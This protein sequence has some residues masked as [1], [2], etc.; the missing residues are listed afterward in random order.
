MRQ[1]DTPYSPQPPPTPAPGPIS[2][3][4]MFIASM[5]LTQFSIVNL[6]DVKAV[7]LS[8]PQ[9]STTIDPERTAL[10][11]TSDG[12]INETE[13][14]PGKSAR[15]KNMD[16]TACMS[17]TFGWV[18]EW[19][20]VFSIVVSTYGSCVAYLL[21]IR[22]NMSKFFPHAFEERDA[23]VWVSCVPLCALA[24]PDSVGFLAPF[25]LLGL[26]A[27]FAFA[28]VVVYNAVDE[29]SPDQ[30][31]HNLND[32]PAFRPATFPLALSIAAFCNEG[33]V[34]L[35]PTTHAAMKRPETYT[36]TAFWGIC[37]FIVCY[38]AVG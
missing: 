3:V 10:L 29:M 35:T 6:I 33:I 20:A 26:A 21:F 4:F 25:S 27:A 13:G 32:S 23:W 14:L 17:E 31:M 28:V 16:F 34:V 38:M 22:D 18:G 7:L 12:T 30:F 11:P 8:R 37:Y 2:G 19:A 36:W 5:M 24:W 9:P 1:T 15:E